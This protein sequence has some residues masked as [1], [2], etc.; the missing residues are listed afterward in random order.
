[1]TVHRRGKRRIIDEKPFVFAP[2]VP[3]PDCISSENEEE[4]IAHLVDG[5]CDDC[6]EYYVTCDLKHDIADLQEKISRVGKIWA[7]LVRKRYG[8]TC[9]NLVDDISEALEATNDQKKKWLETV[10]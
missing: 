7:S 2:L 6:F 5:G 8:F 4:R 1:M 9:V 10:R 3:R